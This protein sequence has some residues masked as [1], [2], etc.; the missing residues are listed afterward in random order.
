MSE[1][2]NI[3]EAKTQL[4]KLVDRAASGE[5]IIIARSGRPV[6]RLVALKTEAPRRKPG[7]MKG[8]MWIGPD[9]DDPLPP[10]LFEGDDDL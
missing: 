8:H 9:F 2:I 5:E 10:D 3:Y 7:R 1:T 4:S 6:A